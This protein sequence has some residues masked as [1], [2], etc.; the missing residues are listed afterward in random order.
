[1]S[2]MALVI[3]VVLGAGCGSY[4]VPEVAEQAILL[5][6]GMAC[7]AGWYCDSATLECKAPACHTCHDLPHADTD[8]TVQCELFCNTGWGDCNHLLS[9]GCEVSLQTVTNCNGCG[10]ACPRPAHATSAC[11]TNGCGIG[12]CDAGWAD[13]NANPSD[14]CETNLA[15]L[16]PGCG[17]CGQGC[18]PV[19]HATPI[20]A[21]TTCLLG[22]CDAGWGDCN[23]VASDGCETSLGSS[24]ANCGACGHVCGS[25]QICAAG[26]CKTR[27]CGDGV[28]DP[29]ETTHTCS[30][31]CGCPTGLYDC[32]GDGVCRVWKACTINGC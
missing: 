1:M 19:A 14:G 25:G 8:C 17:L 28:C 11:H 4:L 3:A 18:P 10:V 29:G 24:A 21:N 12:N 31:D 7:P 6:D 13:C 30:S 15:T 20:C 32:C 16:P 2:K 5:C 22:A 27:I 9:D 23:H 26:V